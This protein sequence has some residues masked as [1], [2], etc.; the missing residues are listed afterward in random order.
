MAELQQ[1]LRVLEMEK[2]HD[3]AQLAALAEFGV[4]S[5]QAA[6]AFQSPREKGQ[7]QQ[8]HEQQDAAAAD[9]APARQ[10]PDPELVSRVRAVQSCSGTAAATV[11][12]MRLPPVTTG[13]RVPASRLWELF[14]CPNFEAE[15]P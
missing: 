10:E 6:A 11:Y 12:M 3:R 7:Q 15:W 5:A 14:R 8:E 1:Q 9:N 13:A 2:A 4:D